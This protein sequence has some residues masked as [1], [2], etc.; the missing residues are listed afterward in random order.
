MGKRSALS[1]AALLLLSAVLFRSLISGWG[2]PAGTPAAA[3]TVFGIA[4]YPADNLSYVSWAAQAKGGRWL[5]DILYTT[6]EH[7][8]LFFNPLFLAIGRTSALLDTSPVLALNVLAAF[9][10]PVV[11]VAFWSICRALGLGGS[12]TFV[13]LCLALGGGG[14][15]WLRQV[16]GRAG[17]SDALI[18]PAGPDLTYYDVYPIVAYFVAPY[19]ALALALVILLVAAIVRADDERR[20]LTAGAGAAVIGFG[21]LLASV[22]PH[23]SI[24]ILAAYGTAAAAAIGLRAQR[25][26]VVRRLAVGACLAGAILPPFLYSLWVSRQ[27][28]WIEYSSAHPDATHDWAVGFF[29]LWGLAGLGLAALGERL[30]RSPFAFLGA[31][32]IGSAAGLLALNGYIF[33]KLTYGFTIALA[34]LAGV[35]IETYKDR[36]PSL[37]VRRAVLGAVASFAVASPALMLLQIARTEGTT[38]WSE[39]FQVVRHIDRDAA[40]PFPGVL[41]DCGTGVLLPGLSGSRVFCGHWALTDGNR[42]KIALLS[43][44]GMLP[45]AD[46]PP[47]DPGVTESE[48]VSWAG[49]LRSQIGAGTFQYLVLRKADELYGGLGRL[50]PRCTLADGHRFAVLTMCPQ[51]QALLA[52]RLAALAGE[53]V[54][55]HSAARAQP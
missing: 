49:V 9:S 36:L 19:H 3:A 13:A 24:M 40:A 28:V 37:A 47:A 26:L 32:A 30:I 41:T 46:A 29:L 33:P 11:V 17:V 4:A 16:A 10:L 50:D 38:A 34:I 22:R 39:L 20:R 1:I 18:G 45:A 5:F 14:I 55:R 43:R 31:W 27:P 25:P 7:P 8:R 51:V 6:T 12:T 35:A 52:G 54:S 15:S 2:P 44:L 21:W 42:Q 48:V 23:V 53:T